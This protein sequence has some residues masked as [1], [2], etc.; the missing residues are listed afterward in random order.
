MKLNNH[1]FSAEPFTSCKKKITKTAITKFQLLSDDS[2][3]TVGG[4]LQ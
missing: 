2:T 1:S 4:A 3:V